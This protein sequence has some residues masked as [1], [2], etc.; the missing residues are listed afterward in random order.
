MV[1]FPSPLVGEGQGGG[2]A[3]RA[4]EHFPSPLAGE[5]QGGGL[6][7]PSPQ[8]E[9]PRVGR[10]RLGNGVPKAPKGC[11]GNERQDTTDDC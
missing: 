6:L 10:V 2:F 11:E 8:G 4:R 7:I 5:G 1:A 3:S 9:Q